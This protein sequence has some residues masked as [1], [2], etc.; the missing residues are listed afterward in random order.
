MGKWTWLIA[1]VIV[2]GIWLGKKW[3]LQPRYER[4]EVATNFTAK[5]PNGKHFALTDLQGSY[6]LLDFW[7]SWCA[8]CRQQNP[9]LVGIYQKYAQ[10][11]FREAKGFE[12]VSVAIE[13]DSARWQRAIKQDGLVWPYQI[14]DKT[15]SFRF[16]NSPVAKA[17]G[18]RQVPTSYL[19][20]PAGET[21]AVNLDL[22]ML[23]AFL[24]KQ[25]E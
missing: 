11:N 5:L 21:I 14:F 25:L 12:I 24:A 23:D 22:Q 17:Y 18:V 16:L 4:G 1:V 10:A 6:V 15:E 19:I 8:P 20:N 9:T 3:Y 2:A 7:G 13:Q